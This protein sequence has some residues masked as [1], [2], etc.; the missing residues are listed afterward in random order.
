MRGQGRGRLRALFPG[1]AP[2]GAHA[3]RG[4]ACRSTWSVAWR[5]SFTTCPARDGT[6][7]TERLWLHA[8]AFSLHEVLED[9]RDPWGCGDRKSVV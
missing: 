5:V 7:T 9:R 8:T 4:S 3:A 1:T 6:V 2:S